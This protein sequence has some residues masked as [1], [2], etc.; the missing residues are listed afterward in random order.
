ML[1]RLVDI[2][3]RPDGEYW[4]GVSDERLDP[5]RVLFGYL[6][7]LTAIAASLPF[8]LMAQKNGVGPA[9]LFVGDWLTGVV[10]LSFVLGFLT[11][12]LAPLFGGENRESQGFVLFALLHTPL[13]VSTFVGVLFTLAGAEGLGSILG[14]VGLFYGIYLMWVSVPVFYKLKSAGDLSSGWQVPGIAVTVAVFWFAL[15]TVS[16]IIWGVVY[17]L[18][19][20]VDP[21]QEAIEDNYNIGATTLDRLAQHDSSLIETTLLKGNT[22]RFLGL[23]EVRTTVE[24]SISSASGDPIEHSLSSPN[25]QYT[26]VDFTPPNSGTYFLQMRVGQLEGVGSEAE[27]AVVEMYRSSTLDELPFSGNEV[28]TDD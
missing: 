15:R 20:V 26:S 4:Q 23:S 1:D 22:Y 13:L 5:N 2:L 14:K 28:L 6:L 16:L 9:L 19:F 12:K 25:S 27:S 21:I 18:N 8:V 10:L 17:Q 7:P 24:I 11:N 3:T